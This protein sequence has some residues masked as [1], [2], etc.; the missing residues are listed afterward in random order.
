MQSLVDLYS[1]RSQPEKKIE[2]LEKFVEILHR[3]GSPASWRRGGLLGDC[4]S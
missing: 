2:V 3:Y 4:A 1:A